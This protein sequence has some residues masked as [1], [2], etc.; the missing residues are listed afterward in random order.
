MSTDPAVKEVSKEDSG[1]A[2]DEQRTKA[3]TMSYDDAE[4]S[5][6]NVFFSVSEPLWADDGQ[7]AHPKGTIVLFHGANEFSELYTDF[8][9]QKTDDGFRV[10][11]LDMPGSGR[12]SRDAQIGQN[13]LLH[14]DSL[15]EHSDAARKVINWVSKQDEYAVNPGGLHFVSSLTGSVAALDT[16]SHLPAGSVESITCINPVFDTDFIDITPGFDGAAHN[17]A[18]SSAEVIK[19]TGQHLGSLREQ[20]LKGSNTN[21]EDYSAQHDAAEKAAPAQWT[22]G[23]VNA[24]EQGISEIDTSTFGNPEIMKVL[25]SNDITVGFIVDSKIDQLGGVDMDET[26]SW[27]KHAKNIGV[28]IN[29][30]EKNGYGPDLLFNPDTKGLVDSQINHTIQSGS[31]YIDIVDR[32]KTIHRVEWNQMDSSERQGLQSSVA[33]FNGV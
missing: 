1:H 16:I 6:Q 4:G 21:Y 28:D 30:T 5:N 9:E 31:P 33:K 2:F 15:D 22:N 26:M 3:Y 20:F 11:T 7:A 29:V 12:S 23:Y 14:S 32:L 17:D 19:I 8:I 24:L 27:A 18:D 10:V 25:K 13:N